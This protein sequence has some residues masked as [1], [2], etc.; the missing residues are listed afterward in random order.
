MVFGDGLINGDII[1]TPD[2][3]PLPSC[4][5]ATGPYTQNVHLCSQL[6]ASIF[7]PWC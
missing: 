5:P 2:R 7:G 1:F 4:A 3:Q 6:L